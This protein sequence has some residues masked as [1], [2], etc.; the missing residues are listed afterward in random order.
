MEELY[1]VNRVAQILACS[2]KNVY[3]L[4]RQGKIKAM[5]MGPRQTRIS[6]ISLEKYIKEGLE[7]YNKGKIPES[8][9]KKT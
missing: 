6:R 4:I 9:L 3:Y 2:R 5:R 1:R 7:K 8:N